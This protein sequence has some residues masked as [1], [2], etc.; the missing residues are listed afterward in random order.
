MPNIDPELA[1]KAVR[2]LR[3]IMWRALGYLFYQVLRSQCDGL[4]KKTRHVYWFPWFI[5]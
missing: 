1:N 4:S 3:A 2:F 5:Y